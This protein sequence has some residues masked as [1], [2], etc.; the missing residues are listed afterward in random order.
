MVTFCV[1]AFFLSC[2]A[3]EPQ[4]YLFLCAA[5]LR[6]VYEDGVKRS[7]GVGPHVLAATVSAPQPPAV[8]FTPYR[9][10]GR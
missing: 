10:A 6:V 7:A 2:E 3:F 4:Y 1:G 9:T 8:P 5:V